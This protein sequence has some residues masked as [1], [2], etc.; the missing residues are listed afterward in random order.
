MEPWGAVG[1][2]HQHSYLRYIISL[3]AGGKKSK[4]LSL[5]DFSLLAP[6]Q[7]KK[8]VAKQSVQEMKR[9][10]HGIANAFKKKGKKNG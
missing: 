3:V 10:L 6:V 4:K 8:G 7:Q 9:A 2:D 1:Q 5:Q